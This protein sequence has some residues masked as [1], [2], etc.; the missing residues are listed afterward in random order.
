MRMRWGTPRGFTAAEGS[1]PPRGHAAA[2]ITCT[3]RWAVDHGSGFA[4]EQIDE[5]MAPGAAVEPKWTASNGGF[6]GE[7][8]RAVKSAGDRLVVL[9]RF[10]GLRGATVSHEGHG[11]LDGSSFRE[12]R[13]LI[14]RMANEA[15]GATGDQI[16]PVSFSST[17]T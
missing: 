15:F 5:R 1:Q 2:A 8:G 3:S 7:T 16:G 17:L 6:W 4:S 11:P 13:V 10:L 14:D 9:S 12:W